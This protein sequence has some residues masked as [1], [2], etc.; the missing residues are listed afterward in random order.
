MYVSERSCESQLVSH[1]LDEDSLRSLPVPF[2]VKHAL[3]GAKVESA[4]GDWDNDL[5]TDRQRTE[6]RGSVVLAGPAVMP[7]SIRVPRGNLLLEPVEN[8]LPQA[9]L[10][11]I[12][13]DRRR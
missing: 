13:E 5:V 8:V 2:S 1:R 4:V 11:I 9:R 7:I 12:H 6:M 10:E 3:P